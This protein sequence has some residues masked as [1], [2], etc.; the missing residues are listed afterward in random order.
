MNAIHI[1]DYPGSRLPGPFSPVPTSP[2]N[3]G[4][5][6]YFSFLITFKCECYCRVIASFFPLDN[7]KYERQS[8][9]LIL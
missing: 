8:R 5:P 4:L 3:P 9:S 6:V 1:F 2:D 7:Y